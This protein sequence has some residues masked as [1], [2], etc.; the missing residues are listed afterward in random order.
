[1]TR[2]VYPASFDPITYGHIDIAERAASIFDELIVGVYSKPMK[3][4]LFSAEERCQLTAEALAGIPNATVKLYSNL[5]V[6]FAQENQATVI[7]RGLRVLS[8]FE[9][10]FQLALTNRTLDPGI[11]TLCLM[12]S[13]EYSFLSS[14]L[15]RDIAMNYG[16]INHL[17]PAHVVE[18]L[19]N[20]VESVD[21][22]QK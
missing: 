18:A 6:Q 17:A 15:L 12:A 19:L 9:W 8:D 5:T 14:S 22:N 11:D 10:E 1:M 4:L 13:Q 20:K 3:D 2:A 7:I 16:P 21:G